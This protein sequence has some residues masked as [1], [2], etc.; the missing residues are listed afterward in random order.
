MKINYSCLGEKLFLLGEDLDLNDNELEE[1]YRRAIKQIIRNELKNYHLT[2][3]DVVIITLAWLTVVNENKTRFYI[4][5]ILDKIPLTKRVEIFRNLERVANLV[6]KGIFEGET[7]SFPQRD[8]L[9][10]VEV[11]FHKEQLLDNPLS[12]SSGFLRL[13]LNKHNEPVKSSMGYKDNQEF[14]SDWFSYLQLIEEACA[15]APLYFEKGS[16][17]YNETQEQARLYWNRIQ[18]K[19]KNTKK[20][21]PFQQIVADCH[22]DHKEQIILMYSLKRGLESN[23]PSI[24]DC[25]VLVSDSKF[26]VYRNLHYFDASARL[27]QNHLVEL[28]E[29]KPIQF[30]ADVHL[31]SVIRDR[32]L[33]ES[34]ATATDFLTEL[35]TGSNLLTLVEPQCRLEDLILEEDLK[36]TLLASLKFFNSNV[37]QTLRKWN[38]LDNPTDMSSSSLLLLFHGKP[39]T[40]KTFAAYAVA[41]YLGKKILTTDISQILSCYVGESEKNVRELFSKYNQIVR[42]VENPPVLLLNEADQFLTKRFEAS[43]SVDRMY[44]QMQ[45]L[46]LEAFENLNGIV[47]CTSNL[48]ENFDTAFSRRFHLKLEFPLPGLK[49][50]EQL[51]K[52]YLKDSIPGAREIDANYFAQKYELSGGQIALIIKNAAIRAAARRGKERRI[53][54]SDLEYYCVLEKDTMFEY[55]NKAIGFVQ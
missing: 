53:L 41:N 55:R 2:V 32:I 36:S 1:Y 23:I 27:I 14:L 7:D 43:R 15:A 49:E 24:W 10:Q 50:R 38:V 31:N 21:I 11:E 40:G 33:N 37:N 25:A 35:V 51:W 26:D 47:I 46:F 54:P 16:K 39:G 28:Y 52:L 20:V 5:E 6:K 17:R 45:N 18:Q 9:F 34:N 29:V 22:L 42:Q 12:F 13:L 48:C 8:R 3:T 4:M 30:Y 44:N 19:L